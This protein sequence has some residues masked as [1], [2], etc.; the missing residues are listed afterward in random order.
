MPTELFKI[1]TS[2]LFKKYRTEDFVLDENF[3]KIVEGKGDAYNLLED[4]LE[5]F[6]EK[7]EDIN[8]AIIILKGLDSDEYRQSTDRKLEL[9]EKIVMQKRHQIQL[10]IFRFAALILILIGIGWTSLYF[11]NKRPSIER[12]TALK[13]VIT[14]NSALVL[15]DG[16]Q[17][18]IDSKQSEVRYTPDGAGVS[19][20]DTT[21]M[22]QPV[23]DNGINQMIVP[24]GKRSSILLS[25]G[26]KVWLNS[27]SRL[28]YSPSLK[29]KTREV[30]LEGEAYF[31]VAKDDGKPFYVKTDAYNIKVYGTKFDVLA[32]RGNHEFSTI[33]VEGKVSL[34]IN[35]QSHSR[36][37]FLAPKQKASLSKGNDNFQIMEVENI[38][39]YIAW[40]NGY[41][42]FEN[43]DISDVLKR[44]SQYYNITIEFRHQSNT[45]KIFGKLDL[46]DDPERVLDGLAIISK[47]R[48]I[49]QK[50]DYVF[51]RK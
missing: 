12:Y 22:E 11:L 33:L 48:Y 9:W 27:G 24:F 13:G 51:M 20:N 32:R 36:E 19:V 30:F 40:I 3:R 42:S 6:P 16:K 49:K 43:E 41:L 37:L 25:D 39:N 44:V 31:E 18:L 45:T 10:R 34:N 38:E 8:L 46:K 50:N 2:E 7:K 21:K 14:N 15:T 4:L 35:G 28:V 29:G 23:S 17:I 1:Y 47:T 5:R 26:T